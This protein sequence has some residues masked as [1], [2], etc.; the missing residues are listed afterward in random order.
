M[1]G[2][3]E[4]GEGEC[5]SNTPSKIYQSRNKVLVGEKKNDAPLKLSWA[6]KICAAGGRRERNADATKSELIGGPN[7]HLQST[8]SIH[9][10]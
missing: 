8:I 4:F 10:N 9:K 5:V 6:P 1:H 2:G 7:H 3:R